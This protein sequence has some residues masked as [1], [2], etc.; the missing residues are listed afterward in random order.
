MTDSQSFVMLTLAVSISR[1][2]ATAVGRV[3]F[4]ETAMPKM[5]VRVCR[6]NGGVGVR[7]LW[8]TVRIAVVLQ[9]FVMLDGGQTTGVAVAMNDCSLKSSGGE[10]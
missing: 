6:E 2:F 7:H 10:V 8:T 9:V 4:K 5:A 3:V 1:S